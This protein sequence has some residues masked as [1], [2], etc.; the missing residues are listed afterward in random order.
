LKVEYSS[1]CTTEEESLRQKRLTRREKEAKIG[2]PRPSRYGLK[3][4]RLRQELA[5]A[6]KTERPL[7]EELPPKV[8]PAATVPLT[9][10]KSTSGKE[11][12]GAGKVI[13]YYPHRSYGFI[14]TDEGSVYFSTKQLNVAP[15][16][17]MALS[18]VASL[19][20]EGWKAIEVNV[21]PN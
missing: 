14:A 5:A 6:P 17:G 2:I 18:F 8:E 3:V 12:R 1:G 15:K 19:G 10:F 21:A 11:L 7:E 13:E 9:A 16:N 20:R 4:E